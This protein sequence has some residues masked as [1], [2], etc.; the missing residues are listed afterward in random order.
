M[1]EVLADVLVGVVAVHHLLLVHRR[2][3]QR[4]IASVDPERADEDGVERVTSV[5][6]SSFL[7]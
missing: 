3:L 7:M 2:H 4:H 5:R 6:M 1:V